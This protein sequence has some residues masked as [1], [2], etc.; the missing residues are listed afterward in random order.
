MILDRQHTLDELS[1]LNQ[2]TVIDVKGSINNIQFVLDSLELEISN[3]RVEP[4][5]LFK[6]DREIRQVLSKLYHFNDLGRK[7][8]T[9]K[10][11]I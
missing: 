2:M 9:I 3:S 11:F 10:E 8:I 1:K 7:N 5:S 4:K 6:E